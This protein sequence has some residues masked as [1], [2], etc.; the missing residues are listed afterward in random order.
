MKMMHIEDKNVHVEDGRFII[1]NPF[2]AEISASEL[3]VKL[4]DAIAEYKPG[5]SGVSYL[6]LVRTDIVPESIEAG[7]MISP[8]LKTSK[9]ILSRMENYTYP[10]HRGARLK[11]SKEQIA[12]QTA[13]TEETLIVFLVNMD[14]GETAITLAIDIDTGAIEVN[15]LE[16]DIDENDA[17]ELLRVIN[18]ILGANINDF[19]T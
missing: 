16:L 17:R 19:Y 15:S 18:R 5:D 9:Y 8:L 7:Y 3:A 12:E 6:A 13:R 2:T 14:S 11:F 4:S 10:V 1:D